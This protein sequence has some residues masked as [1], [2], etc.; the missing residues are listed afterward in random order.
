VP[1]R[2]LHSLFQNDKSVHEE[3]T[4]DFVVVMINSDH[5]ESLLKK[6]K[7]LI[8]YGIPVIVMLDN[9]G[10]YL[11]T[12]NTDD[13]Y[14]SNH[15]DSKKVLAFLKEWTPKA[16]AIK[17]AEL[18]AKP[19]SAWVQE[20]V[21]M[22]DN[23]DK[24]VQIEKMKS[25]PD[26]AIAELIRVIR[27]NSASRNNMLCIQAYR[28]LQNLGPIGKGAIPFL[29]TQF[30][31][32]NPYVAFTAAALISMQD[33]AKTA[34]PILTNLLNQPAPF[35]KDHVERADPQAWLIFQAAY[36]LS[37]IDPANTQLAA[38]MCQWLKSS[39]I[40]CRR[41]APLTLQNL[42]SNAE[43]AVPVLREAL[44]DVDPTVQERAKNALA[45]IHPATDKISK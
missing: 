1:C 4:A 29:A 32:N 17:K 3:L 2:E 15:L 35:L 30:T 42:G 9:D 11:F 18:R 7:A 24:T 22:S 45:K 41:V 27:E 43:S 19:T 31:T 38:V 13:F 39:N 16:V 14:E 26:E 10:K 23:D 8:N 25:K 34:V 21:K 20:Y 44:H 12:Q 36:C 40:Y 37:Q 28:G 5:S 33:E 6:Y